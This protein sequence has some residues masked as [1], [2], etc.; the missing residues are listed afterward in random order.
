MLECPPAGKLYHHQSK[1]ACSL[2]IKTLDALEWSRVFT[3]NALF[4]FIIVHTRQ[5]TTRAVTSAA[6]ANVVKTVRTQ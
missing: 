1:D 2:V 6:K 5:M 3:T 4:H